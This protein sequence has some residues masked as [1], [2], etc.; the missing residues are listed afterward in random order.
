MRNDYVKL[1]EMAV[2]GMFTVPSIDNFDMLAIRKYCKDKNKPYN[3]LTDEEIGIFTIR[4]T[5]R[6][7]I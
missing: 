6:H 2:D 1:D 7:A 5:E 3:E 4:R